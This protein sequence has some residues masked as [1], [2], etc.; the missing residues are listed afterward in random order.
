MKMLLFFSLL[1]LGG[2][3]NLYSQNPKND[4]AVP[5]MTLKEHKIVYSAKISVDSSRDKATLFVNAEEWYKKNF[6]TADNTLII[7]NSGDGTVSGTGIIHTKKHDQKADPGDVFF[8][9]DIQVVRGMY[10]YMVH[11]IYG[12]NK[13]GKFYYSDMYNEEQYPTDKPIWPGPYRHSILNDMNGKITGMIAELKR[14]MKS[15]K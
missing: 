5:Q 2:V 7:D 1:L 11:D 8:T 14:E 15:Q 9:I 12:F 6:E 10:T 13:T 3:T 4:G